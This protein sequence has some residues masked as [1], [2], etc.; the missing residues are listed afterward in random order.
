MVELNGEMN[1]KQIIFF[2]GLLLIIGVCGNEEN[3]MSTLATF[4]LLGVSMMAF[5]LKSVVKSI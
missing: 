5:G 1:M 2:T 3:S 4:G